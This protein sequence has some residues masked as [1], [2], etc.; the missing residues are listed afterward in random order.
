MYRRRRQR[1]GFTLFASLVVCALAGLALFGAEP[2]QRA[3]EQ[4]LVQRTETPTTDGGP[5]AVD[6]EKVAESRQAEEERE[7]REREEARAAE[8]REAAESAEREERE[9]RENAQND[10]PD[11]PTQDLY[12]TVPKM[13]LSGDYV[14]NDA[15]HAGLMNGAGKIP[16]TGFP[17]QPSANTYIAS[18][19]YGYEGTG[20]WQHFAA[21][22]SMT[23]GDEVILTDANGTEYRYQ[24]TNVVTVMPTDTWITE[25]VAGKDMV[26]LQT[27]VGPGWSE[28]LVVQAERV[29][30]EV[31]A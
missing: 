25:P 10:P 21:L 5:E 22:P 26:S 1:V 24:V 9:A 14:V 29:D 12:L 15:S 17:W 11:P 4:E 27:C 23:Y 30:V 18:H 13:G 3:A 28:R 19:V 20:S 8:E 2:Y 6:G 16:E 7:A 31:A